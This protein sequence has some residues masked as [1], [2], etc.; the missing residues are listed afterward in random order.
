MNFIK[1]ID[2]FSNGKKY[3][4]IEELEIIK[5]QANENTSNLGCIVY[6]PHGLPQISGK[7]MLVCLLCSP[8]SAKCSVLLGDLALEALGTL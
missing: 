1:L 3:I 7:Y 6:L 4:L 2:F 5:H 8:V